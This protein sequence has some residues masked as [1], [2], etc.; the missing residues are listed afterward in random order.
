MVAKQLLWKRWKAAF[1]LC[2]GTESRTSTLVSKQNETSFY[3]FY[4]YGCF[5]CEPH[6]CLEPMEARKGFRF[7]GTVVTYGCEPP[8]SAGN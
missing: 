8:W 7:L 2:G 5:V 1:S 3:Y 6:V 4:V